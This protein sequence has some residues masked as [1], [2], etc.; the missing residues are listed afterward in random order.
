MPF[1]VYLVGWYWTCRGY[2][3]FYLLRTRSIRDRTVLGGS[4]F[5]Y[6]LLWPELSV[7]IFI[8]LKICVPCPQIIQT[9]ESGSSPT[10]IQ[11][12]KMNVQ[13]TWW[14][15]AGRTVVSSASAWWS[16][17]MQSKTV[18]HLIPKTIWIQA[19]AK[20]HQQST[21]QNCHL[22]ARFELRL[23][24][25]LHTTKL[26]DET[27]NIQLEVYINW[28]HRIYLIRVNRYEFAN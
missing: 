3:S 26:R 13:F 9:V 16:L 21:F 1:K 10:S 20:S 27:P 2:S 14:S 7:D 19:I 23:I 25:P 12:R 28:W 6:T 8:A 18:N 4:Y 5:I 24:T 15:T 17:Y 22:L 11:K